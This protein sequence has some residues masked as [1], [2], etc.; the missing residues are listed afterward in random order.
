MIMRQIKVNLGKRSYPIFIQSGALSGNP[1]FLRP[2]MSSDRLFITS[3]HTVEYLYGER[4]RRF[5]DFFNIPVVTL[6]VTPGEASKSLKIAEE[7]YD[8]LVDHRATRNSMIIAF[9][10]GVVGD[11]AGFVAATFMRGIHY[12]QIPTTLLSQVDSSVGG[13]VGINHSK[14]KNLIGAFNQP[15]FVVIDPQVLKT[16]SHRDIRSGLAEVIKTA[17]IGDHQLYQFLREKIAQVEAVSNTE[18]TESI[19]HSCCRLKAGIVEEDERE[20]GKR[21]VLNF[22]HTIG[23]A[24]ESVTHYGTFFHGEAVC[25]GMLAALQL[26]LT[27]R[28]PDKTYQE[29]IELVQKLHPPEIPAFVS[30]DDIVSAIEKD[31]KR[32]PSGQLWVLLKDIAKPILTK[33]LLEKQVRQS[34][35]LLLKRKS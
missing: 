21:A 13:K 17:F 12:A 1:E 35:E 19:I 24:L 28:L 32:Q 29:S 30:V 31:K 5:F 16:L 4:I 14:G 7:L 9:G 8:A 33:A 6:T 15:D 10:G 23:H 34:V 26:S 27:Q 18:L 25:Y 3:D 20:G 11:L 22:G 2:L